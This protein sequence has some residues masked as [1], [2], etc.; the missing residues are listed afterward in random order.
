M[1]LGQRRILYL[2]FFLIFFIF[3]PIILA[4]SS[5]YRINI[6][7]KKVYETGSIVIDSEPREA[8]VAI[9]GAEIKDLTPAIINDL[10]EGYYGIEISKPGFTAWR[11]RLFVSAKLT[12]F[13]E[14]ARLFP[15]AVSVSEVI[16]AKTILARNGFFAPK[17]LSPNKKE[18]LI[19]EGLE[20]WIERAEEKTFL[21]RFSRD[22]KK[23]AFI[24]ENNMLVLV[25]SEFYN[26][27]KDGRDLRNVTSVYRSPFDNIT[28][29][30]LESATV[31]FKVKDKNEMK[32]FYFD[33]E[34]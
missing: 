25:G 30:A 23:A 32:V 28:D 9:D 31:Y 5:G 33:L 2:T 8:Q 11:K 19:T 22:I 3:T 17:P 21:T 29:F 34:K 15:L 14:G 1:T 13:V 27:E 12:T 20:L 10:K 7:K 26:V 18:I 24:D 4:Y 16:P 6:K